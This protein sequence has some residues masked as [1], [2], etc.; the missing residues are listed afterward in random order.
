MRFFALGDPH[1]SFNV[2]GGIDKPM[3]IFGDNWQDHHQQI[4]E[5]WERV[6]RP[7]DI[8]LVPGDI[9]W[10]MKLE[11]ARYDLEFLGRLPGRKILI[12][13][14]HDLWWQ[15]IGK[16]RKVLPWGMEAIQNDHI[17]LDNGW[18]VC[19]TRGWTCPGEKN[20]TAEDN[21]IYERE[22]G[23]LRL[24]LSSIK[25]K[26]IN[27][28]VML[29]YPPANGK[30]ESSGFIELLQ[31]FGVKHCVY[32]HLHSDSIKGALPEEKWGI[33]FYLASADAVNFTPKL[34]LETDR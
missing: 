5:N 8:V 17:L 18:A 11:E 1:L 24:S 14:N 4:K 7:E 30:H 2:R 15:G 3:D 27:I 9:S 34:I 13:G 31:E 10:A 16:V 6:V 26:D 32:G 22:L 33:R 29:H 12:R 28:L 21:K 23:R 19:G 20:F 25:E